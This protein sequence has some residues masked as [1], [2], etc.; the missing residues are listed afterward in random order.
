MLLSA[1]TTEP[2][3]V[4]APSGMSVAEA[5]TAHCEQLAQGLEHGAPSRPQSASPHCNS[6]NNP[7]LSTLLAA[8][9]ISGSN[10]YW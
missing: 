8:S 3:D 2:L 1:V 6:S 5:F 9:C 4:V 10:N 7:Q